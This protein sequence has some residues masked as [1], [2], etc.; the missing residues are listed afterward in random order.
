[1]EMIPLLFSITLIL[2]CKTTEQPEDGF[3]LSGDING[4]GNSKITV[5]KFVNNGIELDSI[6]PEN[7]SFIYTGKVNEPYFIQLMVQS[8]DSTSSKLTEF[9]IEN[10]EIKISGNSTDYESVKVSGSKSDQVL[11]AYFEEDG[12]LSAR[13]DTLKTEYDKAV[14]SNDA[15]QRKALAK[16][17]NKIFTV[18]RVALLKEYVTNHSNSTVGALLP[19]FCTI[20][21]A[22]K[23]KDY[24]EIY[25]ML[26][27]NIKATGYGQSILE[28][29]SNGK[30]E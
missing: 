25:H 24:Q 21:D 26:S 9:M 8:S 3:L 10:S 5:I 6:F 23:P 29:A 14:E 30:Y 20:E 1:M 12:L 2:G 13:W 17:L 28:K 16:E 27:D 15:L 7:N 22:L 11:K 19:A 18:D 4:L